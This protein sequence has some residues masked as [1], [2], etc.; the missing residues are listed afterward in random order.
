VALL[1]A[2]LD[3]TDGKVVSPVSAL[4]EYGVAIDEKTLALDA[5][6]TAKLRG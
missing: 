6:G 1:P 3:L 5:Q 4:A 2:N